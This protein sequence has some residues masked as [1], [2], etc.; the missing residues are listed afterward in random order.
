MRAAMPTR[1]WHIVLC[2]IAGTGIFTIIDLI[3]LEKLG[4]L[5]SIQIIWGFAVIIPLLIGIVSTSGAGGAPLWK[6]I[7]GAAL[8]GAAVGVLSPI[9]S[10]FLE[11]HTPVEVSAIAINGAWRAFVF[12]LVSVIGVFATEIKMPEPQKNGS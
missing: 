3:Y 11:T 12:T 9:V 5:P 4:D 1:Y 10:G 6:R 2:A 8:C 7:A